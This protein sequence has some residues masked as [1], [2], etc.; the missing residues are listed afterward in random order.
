MSNRRAELRERVT[1]AFVGAYGVEPDLLVA[2]PG[3]VNLIGEHCDYNDGFVL[4]MA[5]DYETMVAIGPSQDD[6]MHIVAA[7]YQGTTDHFDPNSAFEPQADEWKNHVRGS[8]AVLR[9]RGHR[10]A[11]ANLAIAGNV[12]RG[13]GLSSSASLGVALAKVQAGFNEI[14]SLTEIDFALIAKQAEN[15]YVGTACGIMDQ[16]VSAKA[17][18][19]SALL[20]DCRSLETSSVPIPHDWVVLVVHSGVERQLVDSPFNE[21]RAQCE[22]AAA[23]YGVDALRTLSLEQLEANRGQLDDAV[24]RRARHVVTEIARTRTAVDVF[25]HAD[26]GS[27]S[28]LMAQSHRSLREDFEVTVPPVNAL[29]DLIGSQLGKSGGVR[30]TGG[31]F[32]G[33]VVAVLQKS[34]LPKLCELIETDYC[35]PAG[36]AP[37]IYICQPSGGVTALG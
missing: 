13:A 12:P 28:A 27:L 24:F 7:D 14:S 9:D 5:I 16:M 19:G 30:M 37:D 4:P 31:G 34:D 35:T 15:Q 18:A 2:A 22:A 6:D 36:N 11:A 33:C 20:I 21:R 23:H 8:A 1:E 3:R 17:E 25:K 26:M 10:L 29:V 32:G